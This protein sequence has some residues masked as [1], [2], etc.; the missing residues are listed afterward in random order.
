MLGA[1]AK[2]KANIKCTVVTSSCVAVCSFTDACKPKNGPV[3]TE[4]DWNETSTT[5]K[6]AY[7]LSKVT[8]EKAAWEIAKAE[9]FK[10]VTVNPSFV[11]GPPTSDRNDG[12]SIGFG[13]GLLKEK[14]LGMFGISCV[15]V[16]DVGKAH[17]NACL[18]EQSEGRYICADANGATNWSVWESAGEALKAAIPDIEPVEK[19]EGDAGLPP[20]TPGGG[21]D[22]SKVQ[23]KD[24]A[25]LGIELMDIGKSMADMAAAM[26]VTHAA[27]LA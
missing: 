14:K 15:D 20:G 22:N 13:L 8:A 27:H 19:P 10:M 23:S 4:D 12:T 18:N 26:K 7:H 16:R 9:G 25:G 17:I 6:G 1:V 11:V 21:F 24:G 5:Q 3:F 2:H